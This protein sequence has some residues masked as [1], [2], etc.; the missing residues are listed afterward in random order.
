MAR[1]ISVITQKGGVGKTTTVNALAAALNKCGRRVLCIDMDPQ[2]NLSFSLRAET[3]DV[4]TIYDAMTNQT[5]ALD[6]IQRCTTTDIIPADIL[7]NALEMEYTGENREYLLKDALESVKN[8]YDY[9]IIDSPPSLGILTVNV[10]SASKYV[11]LPMLPDI[12]SLQ[13]I[14]KVIETIQYVKRSC[15]PRLEIAGILINKYNKHQKLHK[16]T[17][18][19]AQLLAQ[20]INV[21]VFKTVIRNSK[22]ISEAQSLQCDIIDYQTRSKGAKD[23]Q[24]L[25]SELMERGIF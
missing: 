21:P 12:F 16:E 10:L 4:Y 14:T 20:K 23:Y 19:T 13:G 15:N 6:C 3:E 9:I 7:L 24:A 25:T 18:G 2:A 11:I 22:S 17:Y 1:I 5:D 8:L